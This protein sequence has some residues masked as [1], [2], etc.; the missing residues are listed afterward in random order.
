MEDSCS[1]YTRMGIF[2]PIEV[3]EPL[4]KQIKPNHDIII[5][6]AHIDEEE[7]VTAVDIARKIPEIN[8]IISG[9]EEMLQVKERTVGKTFIISSGRDAQALA[10]TSIHIEHGVITQINGQVLHM[11]AEE[12][13]A[14]YKL[15][16]RALKVQ[17]L[18]QRISLENNDM[19]NQ[20]IMEINQNLEGSRDIVRREETNLGHLITDAFRVES[21]AQLAIMNGGGIRNS[22][23]SGD[24]TFGQILGVLPFEDTLVSVSITG[25]ALKEALE[26]SLRLYPEE[27]GAFL[28]ISG[29]TYTYDPRAEVGERIHSISINNEPIDMNAEYTLA[30]LSFLAHGVMA[31]IC[32]SYLFLV[33]TLPIQIY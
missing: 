29:F 9:A 23:P 6:L 13:H 18:L 7:K 24:V 20:V 11:T 14:G 33:S 22:I 10:H 5:L 4:I 25:S 21:G 31:M 2:D 28:H 16:P 1:Q 12:L 30:L 15:R 26:H 8:V 32:S 19:L 17:E 27:N 3:L